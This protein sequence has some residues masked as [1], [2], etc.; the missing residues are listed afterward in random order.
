[1]SRMV[2][3]IITALALFALASAA[4]AGILKEQPHE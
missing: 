3:D 2:N 1:M 4:I